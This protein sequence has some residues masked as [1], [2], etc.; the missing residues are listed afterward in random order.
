MFPRIALLI[1]ALL[2]VLSN[3]A[4]GC[5]VPVFRYGLEH[6]TPDVYEGLVFHRGELTADQKALV[7]KF[8]PASTNTPPVNL[9]LRTIDLD[10]PDSSEW[11]TVWES[12]NEQRLPWLVVRPEPR[13]GINW[14]RFSMPF[15]QTALD[16]LVNSPAR[17]SIVDRIANEDSVVWVLLESG[18]KEADQKAA[19]TLDTRLKYLAGVLKLPE[20]SEADIANGLVSVG[21]EGLKLKFSSIRVSRDDAKEDAFVD[22]LLSTEDDLKEINA[23]MVFP[24][25]GQG[26]AL[27]T[28]VG[29]GINNETIDQAA[30][31]LVGSCSCEVKDQNPGVDLLMTADWAKLVSDQAET[32]TNVA[33][34]DDKEIAP[35]ESFQPETVTFS[36]KSDESAAPTAVSTAPKFNLMIPV[37]AILAFVA[38]VLMR[39]RS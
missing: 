8:D 31:F 37:V 35:P 36:P 38:W 4:R 13:T 39:N 10:Q 21:A 11:K 28:L 7:E 23:P 29:N 16:K 17:R 33:K 5:S 20:L 18:D 3:S 24:I 26:R 25:F 14:M 22:M 27:Y 32:T 15:D 19:D 1:V 2:G 30:I 6:W 9:K 34:A 12:F